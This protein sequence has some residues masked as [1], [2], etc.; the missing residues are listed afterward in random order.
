MCRIR[1]MLD[2]FG[3]WFFCYS[4]LITH[5]K[6]EHVARA[7]SLDIIHEHFLVLFMYFWVEFYD[8]INEGREW[9]F[10]FWDFTGE[11]FTSWWAF[12]HSVIAGTLLVQHLPWQL[13]QSSLKESDCRYLMKDFAVAIL[14][15]MAIC[16]RDVH[17]GQVH[18]QMEL[19]VDWLNISLCTFSHSTLN[20]E[21][22]APGFLET[23]ARK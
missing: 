18:N 20:L 8:F 13:R 16:G 4:H 10:L 2:W 5:V 21:S 14:L 11:A 9:W 6:T 19:N 22:H 3:F 15:C 12:P 1:W 7:E 17:H 23:S